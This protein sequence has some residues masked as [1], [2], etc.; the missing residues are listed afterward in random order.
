MSKDLTTYAPIQPPDP[1]RPSELPLLPTWLVQLIAACELGSVT[2][3]LPEK[4]MPSE[5]QRSMIS[6]HI[7]KLESLCQQL[8]KSKPRWFEEMKNA[9]VSMTAALAGPAVDPGASGIAKQHA[10]E[11]ALEDVPYWAIV[12]AV[13]GWYRGAY[14]DKHDY[15]WAPAPAILRSIAMIEANKLTYRAVTLQRVLKA[16]AKKEYTEEHRKEML[17]KVSKIIKTKAP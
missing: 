3:H 7:A 17:E 6:S 11:V 12:E 10:Y 8:P 4:M 16:K 1:H 13:R 15:R 2:S 14:G 9:L 5:T